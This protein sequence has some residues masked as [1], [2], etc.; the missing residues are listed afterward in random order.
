VSL[1]NVI[2]TTRVF[3]DK[4][5]ATVPWQL[6]A[7]FDEMIT[8]GVVYGMRYFYARMNMSNVMS[9]FHKYSLVFQ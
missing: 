1:Q 8:E 3:I 2:D 5:Q 7:V 6:V 4:I 9:T